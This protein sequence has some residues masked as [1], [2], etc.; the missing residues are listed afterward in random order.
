MEG[1]AGK[2]KRTLRVRY[3]QGCFSGARLRRPACGRHG[4]ARPR[5][6]AWRVS[7]PRDARLSL[8][9]PGSVCLAPLGDA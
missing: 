5:H 1:K 8:A 3:G 6:L 2:K 7:P 9:P 4:S